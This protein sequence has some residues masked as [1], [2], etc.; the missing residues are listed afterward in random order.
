[1]PELLEAFIRKA[2]RRS[3]SFKVPFFQIRKVL[4]LAAF[5]LVVS[6]RRTPSLT[7]QSRASP[8][9]PVKSLPLKRTLMSLASGGGVRDGSPAKTATE[10]HSAV[11]RASWRYMQILHIEG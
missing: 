4:P 1:M 9:Q 10:R 6:P 8:S 5:S 7:L 3:K 11:S 2:S